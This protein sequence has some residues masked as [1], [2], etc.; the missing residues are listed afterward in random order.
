MSLNSSKAFDVF[1]SHSS[2]DRHSA[3]LI[4]QYLQAQA[5]RCWKAPDDIL[6]GESWPQAILRAISNSHL[7]LLVWSSNATASPEVS[8]ELTLAT[9]NELTVVPFRIENSAPGEWEYHLANIHWL[10]AF[11]GKLEDHLENLSN[12]LL[13]I[14]SAKGS[15]TREAVTS[16]SGAAQDSQEME[17]VAYAEWA[18]NSTLVIGTGAAKHAEGTIYTPAEKPNP[19]QARR[20]KREAEA[21][22]NP[23][24]PKNLGKTRLRSAFD[25]L[26]DFS[27]QRSPLQAVGFYIFYLI[28]LVLVCA[29]A[30]SILEILFGLG[31]EEGSRVGNVLAILFC[32]GLCFP[33][34]ISKRALSPMNVLTAL[35]AG[36]LAALGGGLLG[37]LP[38][39]FFTTL[40]NTGAH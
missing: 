39:C 19:A 5:V 35:C 4:K 34:L 16:E 36:F 25:L 10:D 23:L 2:L 6:P 12:Y 18:Q 17:D 21:P 15:Y 37:L 30:G 32:A 38:A 31:F 13:H 28:V 29:L 11:D 9:R 33:I 22:S 24:V 40:K 14:L 8:K 7:M 20:A 26:F 3:S 1:I 27:I